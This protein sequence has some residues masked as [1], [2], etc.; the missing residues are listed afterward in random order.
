MQVSD[1]R[2]ETAYTNALREIVRSGDVLGTL[3]RKWELRPLEQPIEKMV[4][5]LK[6]YD[7]RL[8]G[9]KGPDVLAIGGGQRTRHDPSSSRIR[10]TARVRKMRLGR[11]FSLARFG[12]TFLGC[13]MIV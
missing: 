9:G 11:T 8:K 13:C 6:G 12:L 4:W 3:S 5:S 1:T 10:G 2:L 7:H